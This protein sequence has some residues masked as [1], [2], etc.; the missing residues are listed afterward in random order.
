[1]K[2]TKQ[3]I[4]QAAIEL[5]SRDTNTTLDE[6]AQHIGISRRTLHRHYKGKDD[7]SITL[8]KHLA[9]TYLAAV[10]QELA[11]NISSPIE[12]LKRLFYNDIRNADSFILYQ[13]LAA[14][15]QYT[16]ALN[17]EELEKIQIVYRS[18]FH[19]L[20]ES[21]LVNNLISNKWMEL[22]YASTVEAVITAIRQGEPAEDFMFI[23]WQSFWNG[24]KK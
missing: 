3:A 12:Q 10:E 24:I 23:A 6:I 13:K 11:Q 2:E 4:L 18:L 14:F 7:L 5:W 22:F 20:K 17:K 15:Q 1:M 21:D 8:L 16:D 19:E 9:Q